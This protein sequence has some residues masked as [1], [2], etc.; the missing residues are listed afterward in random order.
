MQAVIN[1]IPEAL[2]TAILTA[3][4]TG[5]L[6]FYF[7]KRTENSFAKSLFEYQTKYEISLPNRLKTLE[8]LHNKFIDF[9][10]KF[11]DV[12]NYQNKDITDVYPKLEAFEL[13]LRYSRRY[14]LEEEGKDLDDIYS[15][16]QH[17]WILLIFL[18]GNDTYSPQNVKMIN[19]VIQT[20]KLNLTQL[21]S[22]DPNKKRFK[23]DLTREINGQ[24]HRLEELYKSA[25][26]IR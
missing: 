3:V 18:K 9:V 6:L 15:N 7:Q 22:E 5:L 23:D 2:A 19:A 11:L 12:A 24:T 13:H 26:N 4:F 10:D 21:D 20:S 14:L 8:S 16:G 17:L 1:S 25:A